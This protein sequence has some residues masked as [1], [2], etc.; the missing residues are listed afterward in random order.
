L[1][2]DKLRVFH[3]VAEAGSFTHAGEVLNVS[4]SAVSR[5]ISTLEA[6]LNVALF[7]R[8][9]RGLVMTEQGELLFRAA[10]DILNRLKATEALLGD[11]KNKPFG[12]LRV[13]TTVGLGST[14][15]TPNLAG[16]DKL[17]PDIRLQL[18]LNDDEMDLARREA[19]VAIWLREP[20]QVDLIRRKLFRVH[21][22]AY[23]SISYI[24]SKGSPKDIHDL[25][26]H[27]IVTFGGPLPTQLREVNWLETAGRARG[28]PRQPVL[29][30][31][32]IFALKQAVRTDIGIAV[33]PDYMVGNDKEFI[34]VL[35]NVDMPYFDTYFV[36]SEGVRNSKR[37]RVFGD[38]L[39]AKARKWS[40]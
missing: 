7:S 12:E 23:A 28:K 2:W 4:Q 40:F 20:T 26:H 36:Y 6:D 5:Q 39:I 15:L 10:D 14:W 8:H 37:V 27:R 24:N 33:L 16:F 29:R 11:S 18:L 32:S 13:T 25:D 35:P 38:F 17:Y 22:R 30:I 21:L 3:T 19:D 31:N 34:D 9:A 1:D